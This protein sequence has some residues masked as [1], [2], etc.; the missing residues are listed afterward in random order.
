MY[1]TFTFT[2]LPPHHLTSHTCT[3]S[4]VLYKTYMIIV[5]DSFI[6]NIK[7][8]RGSYLPIIEMK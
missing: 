6:M 7:A 4:T 2:S 1:T 3:V 5:L 8:H